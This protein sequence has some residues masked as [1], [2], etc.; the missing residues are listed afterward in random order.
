M[1]EPE[2]EEGGRLLLR[3]GFFGVPAGYIIWPTVE[4]IPEVAEFLYTYF[5][6]R[7]T[8]EGWV[9]ELH[10]CNSLYVTTKRSLSLAETQAGRDL[11][12]LGCAGASTA[13]DGTHWL[14]WVCVHPQHRERGLGQ[15]LCRRVLEYWGGVGVRDVY[16]SLNPI[17]PAG[18]HLY[19]SLGFVPVAKIM[20]RKCST[21]SAGS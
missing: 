13:M 12:I 8:R 5:P 6:Y 16:V 15:A 4:L 18:E 9:V 21:G 2:E 1:S 7:V 11:P 19:E 14:Q 20:E 10:K 3:R 17:T